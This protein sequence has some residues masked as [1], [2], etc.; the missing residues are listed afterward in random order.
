MPN[1]FVVVFVLIAVVPGVV[2]VLAGVFAMFVCPRKRRTGVHARGTARRH[3]NYRVLIGLL[4][5]LNRAREQG[6][7]AKCLSNLRLIGQAM[8]MYSAENKGFIVP[9]LGPVVRRRQRP[10]RAR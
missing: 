7:M 4:P 10:R 5:A 8:N 6:R 1:W 2:I 3:R 9:G